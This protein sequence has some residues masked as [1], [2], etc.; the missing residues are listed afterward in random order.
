MPMRS[1]FRSFTRRRPLKTATTPA[2]QKQIVTRA[3]SGGMAAAVLYA[4][5]VSSPKALGAVPE[6]SATKAHHAKNGKGFV[7]PWPS[8]VDF[9]PM[10]IGGA[11]IW[12]AYFCLLYFLSLLSNPPST[13]LPSS[14]LQT[15]FY[16]HLFESRIE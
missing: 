5:S 7:N 16:T 14:P 8:W 15:T 4:C 13:H 12:Y 6:E 3:M 9:N 2:P 10:A 1:F 11:M